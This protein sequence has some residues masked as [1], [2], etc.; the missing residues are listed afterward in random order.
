MKIPHF[1]VGD[2]AAALAFYSGILDYALAPGELP[3]DWVLSLVRGD[4]ELMLTRLEVTRCRAPTARCWSTKSAHCSTAGPVADWAS[5]IEP[6]RP[7]T[8]DRVDQSWGTRK[9]T[10]PTRLATHCALS[11]A[12]TGLN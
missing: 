8:S 11:S 10:S 5:R 1:Y 3:D 6:N 9:S 4:A 2:M 12:R 7:S